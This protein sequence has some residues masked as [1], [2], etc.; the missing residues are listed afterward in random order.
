MVVTGDAI[1]CGVDCVA[2]DGAVVAIVSVVVTGDVIAVVMVLSVV[3]SVV[4][5][6][7]VVIG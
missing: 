5:A 7:A 6:G 3:V 1:L 2:I 4:S